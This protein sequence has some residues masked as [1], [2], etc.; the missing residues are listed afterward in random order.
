MSDIRIS[1]LPVWSG[2]ATVGAIPISI[3]GTTYQ[4][5]PSNLQTSGTGVGSSTLSEILKVTDTI[6]QNTVTIAPNLNIFSVLVGTVDILSTKYTYNASNGQLVITDSDLYNTN[7]IGFDLGTRIRIR[8]IVGTNTFSELLLTATSNN[9]S[10][11][12]IAPNLNVKIVLVGTLDL[13]PSEYTYVSS[14][15]QLTILNTDLF[16]PSDTGLQAGTKVRVR[17]F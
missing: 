14:T 8:H 11:F 9:T 15:G 2:V 6:D 13:F 16:P 17:S 5:Q 3:S 4:V 7:G 12:N 10:V 1:E